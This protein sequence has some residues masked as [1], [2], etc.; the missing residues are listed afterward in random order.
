MK[1]LFG[2]LSLLFVV[3]AYVQ[4]NDPDPIFWVP[5]YLVPAVLTALPLVKK[6]GRWMYIPAIA[7]VLFGLS[8][9]PRFQGVFDE[10]VVKMTD[11]TEFTR[12]GLGL[13][14]MGLTVAAAARWGSTITKQESS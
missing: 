1:I 14:L 6:A 9:A 7:Y 5:L 2:L 4:V 12:E 3:G 8:Y 10:I 11:Q 13:I